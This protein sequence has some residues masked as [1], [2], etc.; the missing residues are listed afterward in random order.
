MDE[1]KGKKWLK[2]MAIVILGFV[3][4][5]GAFYAAIT[6]ALHQMLNP[7]YNSKQIEKILKQQEKNFER[8]E[9]E[10]GE[11]PF[12][13]K[14]RPMLVNLVKESNKYKVIVDLK[15]LE[16]DENG[17]NVKID[18]NVIFI[19]GKLDKQTLR[20]EE[21][22]SFS[23]SYYLDEK[24]ITDKITKEKNGDKFIITIPF[25]D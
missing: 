4:I 10:M 3:I 11:H 15:P 5:F 7:V 22:L 13:P 12:L 1:N 19:N 20:G 2:I 8:F 6:M 17:V 9:Y 24:L 23:Q 16:G 21:I 18:D 14:H 25:K